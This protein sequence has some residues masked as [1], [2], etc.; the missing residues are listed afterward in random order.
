V[1][2]TY[3]YTGSMSMNLGTFPAAL[4]DPFGEVA[5]TWYYGLNVF[6]AQTTSTDVKVQLDGRVVATVP[7]TDGAWRVELG[8]LSD[9]A[10]SI[11]ATAFDAFGAAVAQWPAGS[12]TVARPLSAPGAPTYTSV[13]TK[14]ATVNW[15]AVA[16]ATSYDLEAAPDVSGAPGAWRRVVTG[17][18]HTWYLDTLGPNALRWYRVRGMAGTRA[19]AWSAPSRG[20][21]LPGTAGPITF[22]KV[23]HAQV[24]LAWS[25]PS[26]GAAAYALERAALPSG[27]WTAIASGQT[28]GFTDATVA[29]YASFAYRVRALNATAQPGD[30]SATATVTT[31]GDPAVPKPAAPSAPTFSNVTTSYLYVN[32][33]AVEGAATYRIERALE[34]DGNPGAWAEVAAT[35]QATF[36]D[37]SRSGNT[38]YFYR[39]RAANTGGIHRERASLWRRALLRRP[40][41]AQ[42]RVPPSPCPGALRSEVPHP[43]RWNA[44]Q[45]ATVRG[46][47]SSPACPRSRTSMTA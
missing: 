9:G 26:G 40:R 47:P 38:R 44:P 32:W 16:E 42:S 31:L 2:T 3:S 11:G 15:T 23:T 30:W 10:H 27:Q 37:S 5:D 6:A 4:A 39:V 13:G 45:A 24:T 22:P 34:V 19:G 18:A 20:N 43:T 8:N 14:T 33:T 7:C 35:T 29:P 25:E 12:F 17:Q 1:K 41:S 21:T 36:L 46:Q 28:A